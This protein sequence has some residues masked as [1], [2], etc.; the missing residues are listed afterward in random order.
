MRGSLP[1]FYNNITVSGGPAPVRAYIAEFAAR[2][3]G[4]GVWLA[5]GDLPSAALPTLMRKI[6]S[7]ALG[8]AR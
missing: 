1:A 8:R 5:P 7:H 3:N 2:P 6:I 4:E